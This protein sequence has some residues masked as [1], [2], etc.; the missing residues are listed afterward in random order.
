MRG[1]RLGAEG[2]I[3]RVWLEELFEFIRIP[4]VSA[5]PSHTQDVH[6]ACEWVTRFV[7]A[8]GGACEILPTEMH[9]L[10]V[11]EV[12]AS[13]RL[14]PAPTII[15]YGHVDVQAPG[16]DE[17]WDSPAFEPTLR[18][19]WLYARGAADDKGN[20]FMLLK[21]I[22]QLVS[23]EALPVNVRVL[24]DAEEEILGR[25]VVDFVAADALAADACLIFDG[26]MPRRGVPAFYIG[27]RGLA[28]FHLRVRA[29]SRDLHS[30]LYG[31]AALNA[32]HAL[33]RVLSA[34]LDTPAELRIGSIE[35][36][37]DELSSWANLDPGADVLRR[38]GALPADE[39]S[40]AEFYAR[41]LALPAVEVGGFT[42]GEASLQK[43]VMPAHAEANVQ[44][45]LAPGQDVDQIC[46]TF[47]RLLRDACPEGAVLD[48]ERWAAA[49][50]ALVDSNAAA[51]NLARDAFERTLGASPLLVRSGGTLPILGALAARGIPTVLTG[52]DLPEGNIHAPNERL[53][54]EHLPLGVAAA[55][56]TLSAFRTLKPAL[57]E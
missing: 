3:D 18:D 11:G 33:T 13:P 48:V 50:G 40:V 34:V 31:G 45:R 52:F 51:L 9:P 21:A 16:A 6:D 54:L 4:S 47:E 26:P 12:A 43:N 36:S 24:C 8:M 23:H 32:A 22:E 14:G 20:L 15:V 42:S 2:T 39:A 27:T 35:P 7:G 41:T 30:G 37:S 44:I 46:Q 56:E 19:G 53:L 55:R 57:H 17:D 1:T 5:D 38:E 49:P 29:G 28:F 10:V 25:S